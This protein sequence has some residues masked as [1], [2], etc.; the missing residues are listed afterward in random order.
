MSRL[1]PSDAGRGSGAD[2]NT[3]AGAGTSDGEALRLL[4]L[5][6][7]ETEDV[8][9]SLSSETARSILTTLHDRSATASEV[10][11]AVDTSIQNARHH[12]DNLTDAG[13]VRVVET[14][15]SVKGREMNVYGPVEDDLIVC[16]GREDDGDEDGERGF[17]ESIRR[18][19]ATVVAVCAVALAVQW[20]F[21]TRVG[22]VGGP[23]VAPRVADGFAGGAGS[24]PAL[25]LI[26][27]GAAFLA[28][29]LLVV[30]AA[31]AWQYAPR[32]AR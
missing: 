5:D 4:W 7:D 14:R 3:S 23:S 22:G 17:F 12:I 2:T 29:G 13:L 30:A 15:R 20:G 21:G 26:S 18:I 24:A 27:P 25:G 10:A 6:D 32:L 31:L 28:G 16:V 11:D 19:V 9:R 1:T 8:I